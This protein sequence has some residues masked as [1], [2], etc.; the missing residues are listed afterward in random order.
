[1]SDKNIKI[2]YRFS[3]IK[4]LKFS[5]DQTKC[6]EYAID[7]LAI[8]YKVGFNIESPNNKI[9]VK[10]ITEI[11]LPDCEENNIVSELIVDFIFTVDQLDELPVKDDKI[12]FPEDFILSLLSIS[13]GTMRG[14]FHERVSNTNLNKLILPVIHPKQLV[15]KKI[16]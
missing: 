7:D 12:E 5:I 4:V 9:T 13:Y 6:N 8:G 10:I 2:Q 15:R 11:M 14:I 3:E 16:K 1:M